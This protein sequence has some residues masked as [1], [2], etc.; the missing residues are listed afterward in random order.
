MSIGIVNIDDLPLVLTV[1]NI[2]IEDN[3][4]PAFCIS[5]ATFVVK[6]R[7]IIILTQLMHDL[8][9]SNPS[10][11]MMMYLLRVVSAFRTNFW[12]I[13]AQNVIE[14]PTSVACHYQTIRSNLVLCYL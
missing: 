14:L 8:C 6:Y 13:A 12:K 11:F 4:H 5:T 3:P 10:R 7:Q 9:F 2:G 1:L